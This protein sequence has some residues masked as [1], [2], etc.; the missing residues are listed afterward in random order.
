MAD[1]EP[2]QGPNRIVNLRTQHEKHQQH[3]HAINTAKSVIHVEPPPTYTHLTSRSKQRTTALSTNATIERHNLLLLDKMRTILSTNT[4]A[5]T[6]EAPF[7]KDSL[8]YRRR[9]EDLQR[10]MY[11]NGKILSAS[12]HR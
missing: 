2:L 1:R 5:S 9:K 11:E 10:I 12:S 7:M 3:R 4:M 8:N 6:M